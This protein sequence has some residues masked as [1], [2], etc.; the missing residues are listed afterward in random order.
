MKFG[1]FEGSKAPRLPLKYITDWEI[2]C[3]TGYRF[4]VNRYS[5]IPSK[6]KFFWWLKISV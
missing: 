4:C 5:C 6:L 3:S 2:G 1:V